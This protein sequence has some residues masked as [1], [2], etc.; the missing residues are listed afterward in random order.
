MT[1]WEKYFGNPL[2]AAMTLR[3]IYVLEST[4]EATPEDAT[5]YLIDMAMCDIADQGG[6]VACGAYDTLE[7]MESEA[8]RG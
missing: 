5:E 2:R 8:D 6:A 7:W 4:H 3:D 1:N